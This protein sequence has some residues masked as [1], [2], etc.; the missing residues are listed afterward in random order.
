[1]RS[2]S[3]IAGYKGFFVSRFSFLVFRFSFLVYRFSLP[4]T[5]LN[6]LNQF[7]IILVINIQKTLP[8]HYTR[9]YSDNSGESHFETVIVPIKR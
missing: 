3:A 9:I 4:C 7:L 2:K 1:M 8:M 6:D 5:P